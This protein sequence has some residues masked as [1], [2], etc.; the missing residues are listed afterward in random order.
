MNQTEQHDL[1]PCPFC[2]APGRP[3][4][5][6]GASY[7][8]KCTGCLARTF[9][10]ATAADAAVAWNR[11]GVIAPAAPSSVAT[12]RQRIGVDQDY[13]LDVPTDV[14]RAMVAQI[15]DLEAA[16]LAAGG[17]TA[18]GDGTWVVIGGQRLG[19]TMLHELRQNAAR[20][21]WLRDKADRMLC[22][23]APM[24]AS[25]D[26]AGNLIELIDGDELDA[27]VD[28]AMA[29]PRAASANKTKRMGTC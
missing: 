1:A 28:T 20:Y 13:P 15:A 27:A 14:E 21:L 3:D 29:R 6:A 4:F 11:R 18:G 25:L 2:S 26:D 19:K 10:K 24:V 23:A 5:I 7:S 9:Y 22:T 8:I 17:R 16:L 12:W